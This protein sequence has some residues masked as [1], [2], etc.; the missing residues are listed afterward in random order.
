M[1]GFLA[2]VWPFVRPHIGIVVLAYCASLL[3]A[4]LFLAFGLWIGG[5]LDA[6]LSDPALASKA[7][8]YFR[9]AAAAIALYA[10][11]GFLHTYA[12]SW[13]GTQVV[14]KI[15]RR[16]FTRIL[17][18]G[19]RAIDEDASGELQTRVIADTAT[20]GNFLGG[21]MP[22]MFLAVL[23]CA[24]GLGGALY[25]R[26]AMPATGDNGDSGY[27]LAAFLLLLPALAVMRGLRRLGERTQN[28]E[29]QAGQ[30]AGEAFRNWPVVHAFNQVERE[31]RRFG[32]AADR[33]ARH[34]LASLRL[35]LGFSNAVLA[36]A[37]TGLAALVLYGT[38]E[39]DPEAAVGSIKRGANVAFLLLMLRAGTAGFQLLNLVTAASNVVGRTARIVALLQASRT[40]AG[41]APRPAG[42]LPTNGVDLAFEAVSHRYP[43]RAENALSNV[44]FA[45]PAGTRVAIVGPSGAGK[46]TLFAVLLRLVEPNTGRVLGN[47]V[48]AADHPLEAWRSLF[49]F[50]PQAEHLV[51]GTVAYNIAYGRE[52]SSLEE[53]RRA[54]RLAYIHDFIE[55]LPNGYDTDLGE[56]GSQLSG[57][58]RQRVNLARAILL[59]PPAYLLDEATSAL[60]PDSE[61]AVEAAVDELAKTSTVLVIAHRL[62]TVRRAD[63]IVVMDRGRVVDVGTHEELAAREPLY[64][65]LIRTERE[66][67]RPG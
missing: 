32:D 5:N 34:F 9:V 11:L 40:R 35:R 24:F 66:A 61:R 50:V 47:G 3:A 31:S 46:S 19:G 62:R 29:A 14:R 49:G 26:S 7:D 63:R 22:G 33:V 36:L 60:D 53:I 28:A 57:G 10:A 64:Q 23:N 42:K 43:T 16:L 54:A 20:L 1:G 65:A 17:R 25:V 44:S 8:G 27:G 38:S 52:D 12:M 59:R 51:S 55:T 18:R 13:V 15:R 48:D 56:V 6:V 39:I 30:R 21:E 58:Q 37:F 2:A 45:V 4:L 41:P 67:A